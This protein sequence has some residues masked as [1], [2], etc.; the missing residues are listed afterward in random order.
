[1]AAEVVASTAAEVV[2]SM[3]AAGSVGADFTVGDS[4]AEGSAAAPA[5]IAVAMAVI[6]VA[7]EGIAGAV[8]AT[9]VATPGGAST[10]ACAVIQEAAGASG[11]PADGH[12]AVQCRT[13]RFVMDNGILSGRTVL[14]L[15]E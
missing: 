12:T 6:A 15:P 10:A 3:V 11:A 13:R 9:A 1:M 5:V 2:A 7:T 4:P 8:A 14:P